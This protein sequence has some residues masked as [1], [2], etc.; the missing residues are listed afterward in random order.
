MFL[1]VLYYICLVNNNKDSE[2]MKLE[3]IKSI[4]TDNK[5]ALKGK[6]L[7]VGDNSYTTLKEFGLA[8]LE[9]D[10][11]NVTL[12][13]MLVFNDHQMNI[14]SEVSV[15][16]A[17]KGNFDKVQVLSALHYNINYKIDYSEVDFVQFGTTA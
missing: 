15:R 1:T 8:I 17:F 5:E 6:V 12:Q 4:L 13:I 2:K 10:A 14:D 16:A 9:E 3:T 11:P 7:E